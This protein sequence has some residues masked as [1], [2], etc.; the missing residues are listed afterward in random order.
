MRLL[1][2]LCQ[3]SVWLTSWAAT[4]EWPEVAVL[5]PYVVALQPILSAFTIMCDISFLTF[6]YSTK[7]VNTLHT[8]LVCRP[9][10]YL[11]CFTQFYRQMQTLAR[12][13]KSAHTDVLPGVLI[14]SSVNLDIHLHHMKASTNS[15]HCPKLVS[16]MMVNQMSESLLATFILSPGSVKIRRILCPRSSSHQT[17]TA[18]VLFCSRTFARTPIRGFKIKLNEYLCL[19]CLKVVEQKAEPSTP[20]KVKNRKVNFLC[21]WGLCAEINWSLSELI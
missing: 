1:P 14:S 11:S 7:L 5:K 4:S 18:A 9:Q 3:W 2:W 19:S 20:A 17:V 6:C 10:A 8:D 16:Q 12:V 13:M 15:V 21:A